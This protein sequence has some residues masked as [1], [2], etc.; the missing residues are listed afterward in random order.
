M[1]VIQNAKTL[2]AVV[3]CKPRQILE[4]KLSKI[5]AVNLIFVGQKTVESSKERKYCTGIAQAGL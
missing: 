5:T 4:M 1:K 2:V 3:R